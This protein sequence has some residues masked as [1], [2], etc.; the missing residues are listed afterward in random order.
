MT[1]PIT[2]NAN[3]VVIGDYRLPIKEG[4]I[5]VSK[6]TSHAPKITIGETTRADQVFA[7]EWIGAD[8]RAGLL[9]YNIDEQTQEG[10]FYWSTCDTMRKKKL[11]LAPLVVNI[12]YPA[13]VTV[14]CDYMI[15]FGSYLYCSF[16]GAIYRWSS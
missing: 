10:R 5:Q 3:E 12:S 1:N 2:F 9:V 15:E 16:G 7:D 4:K 13:G 6:A 8:W 11:M 14:P